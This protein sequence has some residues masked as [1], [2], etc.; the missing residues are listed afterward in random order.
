M[1]QKIFIS[2]GL[3]VVDLPPHAL[4]ILSSLSFMNQGHPIATPF[5]VTCPLHTGGRDRVAAGSFSLLLTDEDDALGRVS[6]ACW[7]THAPLASGS[8][9]K[10]TKPQKT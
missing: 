7:G 5:L 9:H 6:L 4:V 10:L 8:A 2:R 3:I 1:Q